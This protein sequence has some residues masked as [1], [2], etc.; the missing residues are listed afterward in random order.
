MRRETTIITVGL[1]PAW[2][3]TCRGRNLRWGAHQCIE[4]QSI[5]PAGK[6]LNVSKALAWLGRESIAAGLWGRSDHRQMLADVRSSWPL[7]KVRMTAVD[8]HTRRNVTVVDTA[9]GKEMHLRN[10]SPL[11][12]AKTLRQLQTDLEKIVR[13][14][15]ICVFAGTMPEGRLLDCVIRI[16]KSCA[17]RGAR[18]VLDT[19][20]SPLR[21]IVDTGAVW[22]IKPNVE[23]LCEL[24][25][26]KIK[27]EPASLAAAASR[28][29]DRVEMI[30]ISRGAKGGLLV[31]KQGIWQARCVGRGRVLSTVGCGDYLLAGFLKSF[32]ENR[33]PSRSLKTAI[34]VATAKAWGRTEENEGASQTLREIKVAVKRI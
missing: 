9:N 34:K 12:S 10:K 14:G 24:S 2:D 16:I 27:D 22:L 1:A 29:L 33:D 28:L 8:G 23:E 13:R 7:I 20:G 4:E 19:S 26:R 25:G 3:I 21:K 17:S 15:G 5:A 6:A 18:I 30:L 11:A 32:T 31:T